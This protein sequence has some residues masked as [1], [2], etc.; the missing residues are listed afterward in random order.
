M[1][2]NKF[3][4][5][6]LILIKISLLRKKVRDQKKRRINEEKS[7]IMEIFFVSWEND[8]NSKTK[9][10]FSFETIRKD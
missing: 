9:T 2:N 8:K 4:K 5:V 1:A 3:S 10:K 6:G 7:G